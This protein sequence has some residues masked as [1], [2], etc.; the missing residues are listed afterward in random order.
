MKK[1][2]NANTMQGLN[3]DSVIIRQNNRHNIKIISFMY[4]IRFFQTRNVQNFQNLY[5][6]FQKIK[7]I[8]FSPII[9]NNPNS[10]FIF[11]KR[12]T[13]KLFSSLFAL[14]LQFSWILSNFFWTKLRVAYYVNNWIY[15]TNHKR[16]AINYFWFVI[17]AGIVGM[18]LATIIRL[19]F[20]YPGVGVLAGDSIQYLSIAS[21][22]GVIMVFFMIMPLLFGAFANFLLP[23]QLG[24]HDV[25][26]PRLNSAAFWFLPGGLLMLCQLVCVDRR[27]QRMNCFNIREVQSLLKRKFF[28]DLINSKDYHTL[29][30]QTM[31]GLRFKTNSEQA[32]NTGVLSFYNFGLDLTPKSRL[33]IF[34]T[35][36][37]TPRLDATNFKPSI[38]F[39]K[40]VSYFIDAFSFKASSIHSELNLNSFSISGAIFLFSSKASY[41]SVNF[42]EKLKNFSNK[43][44]EIA[45]NPDAALNSVI[46][47]VSKLFTSTASNV[48]LFFAFYR[49]LFEDFIQNPNDIYGVMR[50]A[51]NS[52]TINRA[53][54]WTKKTLTKL[55]TEISRIWQRS[56]ELYNEFYN[57][58]MGID[59]RGIFRDYFFINTLKKI[60]HFSSTKLSKTS[61]LEIKRFYINND[62]KNNNFFYNLFTI[63]K[64]TL[65]NLL[66]WTLFGIR[67]PK[68][69][70]ESGFILYLGNKQVNILELQSHTS[71]QK[72]IKNASLDYNSW[73]YEV[74][75]FFFC[76]MSAPLFFINIIYYLCRYH[77][78]LL[79]ENLIFSDSVSWLIE[80]FGQDNPV[81]TFSTA[82]DAFD[83]LPHFFIVLLSVH[84]FIYSFY[85]KLKRIVTDKIHVYQY[86]FKIMIEQE[87]ENDFSDFKFSDYAEYL[88]FIDIYLSF[89]FKFVKNVVNLFIFLFFSNKNFLIFDKIFFF[90]SSPSYPFCFKNN[91]DSFNLLNNNSQIGNTKI[92]YSSFKLNDLSQ[93]DLSKIMHQELSENSK[94]IRFNNPIF[95]YDY[96]SGDYFPKLY[97]EAYSFLIPSIIDLT[98]S[99]RSSPWFFSDNLKEMI[100][101]TFDILL[102]NLSNSKK[103]ENFE[104][105]LS[106]NNKTFNADAFYN[107]FYILSTQTNE[108]NFKWISLGSL[109][110]KFNKFFLTSSMQQRI[111]ANWKQLKFTREAWRC[112]LLAARHQKTLFRRYM[113]E[114]GVFWSIE[115]NAKDLIPGWAMITPFSSRTRYTAVGKTDIGLMGVLLVLNSSIISGANFLVTYRYL[116]TLNNRK[117]RDA[118]AFFT[119]A[120]MVASW[121]MILA[122]PMLVIGIIM[123]ISD[124]HWQT[125]FFDYSG[126]GDTVLFQH[127]FWFFG[128]PEVYI[129]IIPTF[130]FTNT[131]MSYYLKKRV[132]AR[133]S[134]LYSLYTIAF[135]GFF[136]WGH[137]M[138]MVGLSHTTRMLFSTLTVMISVPAATKIMHWCVTTV[139]SAFVMELPLLFT[140]TFIFFF[141][142][143]GISGMCV[144]HTGMDVLFH[145]T[146]YVIGH[147]HVMLAGGAMFAC[148]GA[149]YFYF[150]AIFGVKY[151]RI[152]AYLHYTY[153][154]IG[155]LMTVVPMFWLGYAGMP[156]RV[157]DYPA[158]FGGW[159][160]V[161]SAGHMLNVAGLIAFFI[162]I[163]DSLRQSRAAT[164][165]SFGIGRYN[166]R[167]NFY[168][169]EISRL[170]YV[171]QKSLFFYKFN[172]I[173]SIKLNNVNFKNYEPYETVLFS[174]LL[175]KNRK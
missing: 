10:K 20:A 121:M 103:L 56:V 156:R 94:T 90:L 143:G 13:N 129:I 21:A 26:F 9:K 168:I 128:H 163:F 171:Q 141:V 164:R 175:T 174:Y 146:F 170:I 37:S 96:K 167:L 28:V 108:I 5:H 61:F 112:K 130:G 82:R 66:A 83:N 124:R 51:T 127:M 54:A 173:S 93:N 23:T 136:V 8:M 84:G 45:L 55:E 101:V 166:T 159:H 134:L 158:A 155:Q 100:E 132:S 57:F 29:L 75:I 86:I 15:T 78:W 126:G 151:S 60:S 80:T 48:R 32:L 98:S 73:T 137:H 74:Y 142:S 154:L 39:S 172:R 31:V 120:V 53:D 50:N 67:L 22:H 111:Y 19:E 113:N 165:N 157:L 34:E 107:F 43:T 63:Y 71:L 109:N 144:A 58:L 119:E 160:S 11:N 40:C 14:K 59:F 148:F 17:L 125:S 49:E 161:I 1:F 18:V 87:K 46:T 3:A 88:R 162:M 150:P 152:Y 133:A 7:L 27:Y 16:I 122:N 147:F 79:N 140:F 4:N 149:F 72:F 105:R 106:K 118:R 102:K 97:K 110:T 81:M 153:Y 91:S 35:K 114:D 12:N 139:N 52:E 36:N 41:L 77:F 38:V 2:L 123:L 117:M 30:D 64:I 99:L 33:Y 89:F 65:N 47:A 44:I 169:Y 104:I 6:S 68:P 92:G 70:E 135:L 131:M 95:K 62:F 116:S 25:A 76:L 115:R 145:D 24:V 42:F 138:Y 85:E 69:K